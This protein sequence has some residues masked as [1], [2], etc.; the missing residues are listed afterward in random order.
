MKARD[1]YL[2]S[3]TESVA[4][5][6]RPVLRTA[7]MPVW[8]VR[9]SGAELFRETVPPTDGSP[10]RTR[11]SDTLEPKTS[12]ENP[13]EPRT[14]ADVES[15][16]IRQPDSATTDRAELTPSAA[17]TH[18]EG[19]EQ[20]RPVSTIPAQAD[21]PKRERLAQ[22]MAI[23]PSRSQTR[24]S[25]NDKAQAVSIAQPAMRTSATTASLSSNVSAT[26]VTPESGK[27]QL[28][29]GRASH[30][31]RSVDNSSER[32]YRER[33]PRPDVAKRSQFQLEPA[34]VA[35][36]PD[37]RTSARTTAQFADSRDQGEPG[38]RN[39]V[40]IGKIHIHIA[41]PPAPAAQRQIV[42]SIPANSRAALARGFFSSFGL[43]QG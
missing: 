22:D 26:R 19:E 14:T 2:R 25:A 41:P 21:T 3:M 6:T 42:R 27:S 13:V 18:L 23:K 32:S 20:L 10:N 12:L 15:L 5:S 16:S 36:R 40:H 35:E 17:R 39:S 24:A 29:Q 1:S 11:M 37:A 8:P 9:P 28:E 7:P 33:S 43:R 38:S 30:F 34:P 31:S 4:G